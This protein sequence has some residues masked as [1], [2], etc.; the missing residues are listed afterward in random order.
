MKIFIE[1]SIFQKP[2]TGIAKSTLELYKQVIKLDPSIEVIILHKNELKGVLPSEFK[3]VQFGRYIPL[4]MWRSLFLPI[5]IS[6]HKP[7]I[8]HFP[9]NGNVPRFLRNTKV[10][11]TIYDIIPLRVPELFTTI[12]DI[13]R[14]P[15]YIKY[16]LIKRHFRKMTQD[17]IDRSD[18]IINT[19]YYTK[20][21]IIKEFTLKIEPTVIYIGPTIDCTH[22][23]DENVNQDYFLYVGGYEK[24]KGIIKLLETFT[25]LFKE[26]KIKSK[27]VLTGAKNYYS[28]YLK[29]LI[30]EGVKLGFLE[31]KG[32][33]SE[34]E[35][36]FL[37]MNAKALVFLSIYEGFGLPPLEA[38]TLECPV[39]TTRA[40]SLPEVCGDAAYYVDI[41]KD[42]EL[43]EAL[44]K[45]EENEEF[46]GKLISLGKI[47]ASK[48]S[49]E[50][51]S[52]S[53]LEKIKNLKK[54]LN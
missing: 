21:D 26:N 13:L 11:T 40:T 39:I 44:I 20:K 53:F 46:R 1:G 28:H 27:L 14:V 7:D 33:V 48:F 32:Y 37:Y 41:K 17:S 6:I 3:S 45:I 12:Y 34:S 47:Q 50:I 51:I 19:S 31:E 22:P 42:E 36:C 25:K 9:W 2:F 49:W 23:E 10:I 30:D 16:P 29:D 54:K 35:L 24:R 5:Y 52:K 18:L 38:M 4:F 8:V 15:G 43:Y